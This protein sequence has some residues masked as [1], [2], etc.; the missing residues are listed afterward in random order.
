MTIT[1]T[2][3]RR[4]RDWLTE[5]DLGSLANG[6][7]ATSLLSECES[8]VR[9]RRTRQEAREAVES[10]AWKWAQDLGPVEHVE[11]GRFG[12]VLSQSWYSLEQQMALANRRRNVPR[13]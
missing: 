8:L 9:P 2:T 7:E 4:G 1:I 5:V 11:R 13:H 10:T 6:P 3:R 12:L